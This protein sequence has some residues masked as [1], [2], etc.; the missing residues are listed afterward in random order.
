MVSLDIRAVNRSILPLCGF[1]YFDVASY[2]IIVVAFW[3]PTA[4][5]YPISEKAVVFTCSNDCFT[6]TMDASGIRKAY[7]K[8]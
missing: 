6:G 5:R 1:N 4:S 2:Y 3:Y 8:R 7:S